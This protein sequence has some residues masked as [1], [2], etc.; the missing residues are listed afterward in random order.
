MPKE[1]SPVLAA[2][3][4]VALG[5]LGFVGGLVFVALFYRRVEQG[6][7]LIV[8]SMRPEP[9]VS[10]TGRIVYPIL[11]KAEV[12]DISMKMVN[13][14]RRGQRSLVCKDDVRADLKITFYLRVNRTVEDVLKAAQTLGCARASDPQ[15]LA[16]LFSAEFNDALETAARAVRFEELDRDRQQF[17]DEVLSII[18]RDLNGFVLEDVALDH[19]EETP[20]GGAALRGG[21]ARDDWPSA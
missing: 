1:L 21:R 4:A 18:G 19:L 7:A 14:E 3:V 6:Q 17:K 10:F 11:N 20:A 2:I 5:V 13:L 8:T 12:M 16:E 15:A 9:T